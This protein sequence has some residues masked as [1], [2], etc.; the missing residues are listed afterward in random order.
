MQEQIL[1]RTRLQHLIEQ[2]GFYGNDAKRVSMEDAV[3]RLRKAILVTPLNPMAGTRSAELPGFNVDVT[4]GEA[5][6]A[7]QICKEITSMFMEQNLHLRQQQAEDTTQFLAKQLDDAKAKLDE[8]DTK[9][10]AFHTHYT[11]ALPQPQTPHLP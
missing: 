5:R 10:P 9:L 6:L 7:Q 1:S 2:F 8:Q 3:E 4:L 11:V